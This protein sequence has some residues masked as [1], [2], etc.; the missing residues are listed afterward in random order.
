MMAGKRD[1]EQLIMAKA[2][3]ESPKKHQRHVPKIVL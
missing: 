2:K 1:G 3:R